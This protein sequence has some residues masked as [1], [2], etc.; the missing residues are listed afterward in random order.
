MNILFAWF[1]SCLKRNFFFLND[2]ILVTVRT[3]R[4]LS[5]DTRMI[6]NQD[7]IIVCL[8][9]IVGLQVNDVE[10]GKYSKRSKD[11]SIENC[12]S[13][14]KFLKQLLNYRCNIDCM[15]LFI[16]ET[17]WSFINRDL[18]WLLQLIKFI[19]HVYHSLL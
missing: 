16:K 3:I 18:I 6:L 12:N 4:S 2:D 13:T 15:E 19:Y 17:Y 7:N 10:D 1:K 14:A 11:V 5:P 9:N 8:I